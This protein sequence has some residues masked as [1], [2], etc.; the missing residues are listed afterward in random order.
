VTYPRQQG[1][2]RP[3]PGDP[4]RAFIQQSNERRE[5]AANP[6]RRAERSQ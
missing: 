6:L 3:A 5:Q 4:V 2:G 1:G